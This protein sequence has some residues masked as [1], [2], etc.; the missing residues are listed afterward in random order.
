MAAQQIPCGNQGLPW[1]PRGMGYRAPPSLF[2]RRVPFGAKSPA[3]HIHLRR[4][5]PVRV[6]FSYSMP[7]APARSRGMI[8]ADRRHTPVLGRQAIG[9]LSPREGGIYVDATFGAG[10]YSQAI[11]E[12]AG[13]RVIGIDRDRTA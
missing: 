10:G 5:G 2:Y 4:N 13:T 11:L 6:Q 12:T 3:K 8:L 9:L 7:R 1:E